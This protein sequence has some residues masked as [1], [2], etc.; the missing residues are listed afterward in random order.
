MASLKEAIAKKDEEIERQQLLREKKNALPSVPGDRRSSKY[1]SSSP[2]PVAG[3]S[4]RNNA[5]S[6]VN[7]NL[8]DNRR[9][10]FDGFRQS[11]RNAEG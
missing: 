10:S 4:P 8:P 2:S 1:G 3:A 11:F 9:K 5:R 7:R 6:G